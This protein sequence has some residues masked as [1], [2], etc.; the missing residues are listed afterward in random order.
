MNFKKRKA[1]L[2]IVASFLF[3][4]L[5]TQNSFAIS[6]KKGDIAPDF[7]L[8]DI[9]GNIV[10]LSDYKGKVVLITFWA[11]WCEKCWEEIEF[12]Q[13]NLAKKDE[14]KVLLINMETRSISEAHLNKIKTSVEESGI[15]FPV[16]LDLKLKVYQDYGIMALPSTALVD[17][18]GVIQFA[19]SHFY[20]EYKED[21]NGV[22]VEITK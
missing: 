13:K 16:L 5:L 11:T 4:V 15:K 12:I 6:K 17:K 8:S 14:V 9:Y 19:G 22:I 1:V 20:K 2:S 10:K 3:F 18:E 21:I 7:T